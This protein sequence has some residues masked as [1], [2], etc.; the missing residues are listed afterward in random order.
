MKKYQVVGIGNAIVDVLTRAE[1]TFLEM[2]GIQKGIMQ[3][4]EKDRAQVLYGAMESRVQAPGGSVANTLAGLGNLGLRTAFIGRVHDDALGRFYASAMEKDGTDFV[5]APVPGGDLPTSRSMIFVSPDGERSM[6]TYLGISAELGPE[7]VSEDVAAE[8]EIVFLEG[9]LFDKPKGKE[10]FI[11]T[12]RTCRAAGG[13]AGI[14]I[15]D[16]FCVE[17][18]RE[19]FIKLIQNEMDYVIGNED[20]IRSLFQDQ[21]LDAD[22][23]RVAA[24]CPLVV[25]T[26]SGDGVT[27]VH[28][29]VRT[30]VPV[31][32]VIPVDATGAGDQFAAGFL[33]GLATGRDMETCGRMG[34]ICAGEVIS[35]M[36]PRPEANIASLFRHAELIG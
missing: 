22:L 26:R 23:A 13:K 11:R 1:D 8:A 3:L 36:G 32:K 25:C 18:H 31:K 27:I 20:E 10:A 5:N 33:Y 24:I 7:D 16:P 28:N 35:H 15:S 4:V 34:T 29:G 21:D 30:D 19:D 17:R 9:Y 6:N 14:A 2:M 12:A